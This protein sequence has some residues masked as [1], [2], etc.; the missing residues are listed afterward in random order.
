MRE[1]RFRPRLASALEALGY[2]VSVFASAE[3]V[4]TRL[5]VERPAAFLIAVDLPGMSLTELTAWMQCDPATARLPIVALA[6]S[7]R[8]HRDAA[9]ITAI[10]FIV[11]LR[12]LASC[13]AQAVDERLRA[14]APGHRKTGADAP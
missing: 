4:V 5:K 6:D 7:R 14:E 1:T 10:A 9:R 2:K 12:L 13:V 3:A 11:R 8:E